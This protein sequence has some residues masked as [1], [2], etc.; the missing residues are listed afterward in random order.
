M[1]AVTKVEPTD[2]DISPEILEIV[3]AEGDLT[4]LTTEQRLSYYL[5]VCKSQGLNPLTRPF[6]YVKLQGKLVLYANKGCTDQ[7]RKLDN[8][9]I[10]IVDRRVEDDI[11]I[12]TAKARSGDGREDE[13]FGAVSIAGLRGEAKANAV[14]KAITK[15]KRRATLSICGMGMLDESEV[16]DIPGAE[17]EPKNVTATREPPQKP[18]RKLSPMG[19]TL[20]K[21]EV[22][23]ATN[24]DQ[25]PEKWPARDSQPTLLDTA[26]PK[27]QPDPP[28]LWVRKTVRQFIECQ[29]I[30]DYNEIMGG[31]LLRSSL[32][33][34]QRERPE[35][36]E[37]FETARKACFARL[38]EEHADERAGK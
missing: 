7:K 36:H 22:D 38:T 37:Q 25:I 12:V 4:H 15:A 5:H 31:P 9:S 8:I 30:D 29:I 10:E 2:T 28:A 20:N 33:I 24:G 34:L 14:L 26:T 21:E 18:A 17:R 3:L 27:E 6:E 32:E 1:N 11:F 16:A 13:D 23:R 19:T 35:L